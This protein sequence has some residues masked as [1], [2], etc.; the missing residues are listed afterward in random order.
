MKKSSVFVAQ[1]SDQRHYLCDG[2]VCYFDDDTQVVSR[3]APKGLRRVDSYPPA[4]LAELLLG[5][6]K[7]G[8]KMQ[9]SVRAQLSAYVKAKSLA[10][11]RAKLH[12][13]SGETKMATAKKTTVKAAA[14]KAGKPAAKAAA[15]PAKKAGKPAAK[16]AAPAEATPGKRGRAAKFSDDAKIKVVVEGNPKRGTA[17]KRFELYKTSKTVGDYLAAGGLKAD[18]NWDAGKGWITVG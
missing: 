9:E 10:Y 14:K 5:L 11:D 2:A 4:R 18:V 8:R 6:V 13:T 1:D 7:L 3:K 12:V 15:A 16:A 17:A